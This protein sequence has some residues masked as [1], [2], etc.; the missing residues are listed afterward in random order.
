MNNLLLQLS[1]RVLC[2]LLSALLLFSVMGCYGEEQEAEDDKVLRILVE[3]NDYYDTNGLEYQIELAIQRF[4]KEYPDYQIVLEE[5]PK[6]ENGRAEM[7]QKIRTELMAGK[8]PDV[9]LLSNAYSVFEWTNPREPLFADIELSMRNGLFYDISEFYNAD[10]ALQK[11]ELE[12]VIMEAGVLDGARYVLPLRFDI[13]VM[14]VEKNRFAETGLSED[15]FEMGILELI[16]YF[17]SMEDDAIAS[18][19][20]L[21]YVYP[22]FAMNMFPR[23]FDYD[24]GSVAVTR[25]EIETFLRAFQ[26]YRL[27]FVKSVE[28]HDVSDS[29]EMHRYTQDGLYWT[30]QTDNFLLI[31]SLQNMLEILAIG[32]TKGAELEAY[33]LRSADGSVVADITFYGAVS[34]GSKHPKL[35]YEFIRLFLTKNYQWDRNAA[36]WIGNYWYLSTYGWPVRTK[37]SLAEVAQS[38]QEASKFEWAPVKYKIDFGLLTNEDLLVE[39]LP[40]DSARFSIALEHGFWLDMKTLQKYGLDGP[41]DVDIPKLAQTWM[42]RLQVHIDEG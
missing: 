4:A 15:L 22:Q 10:T 3:R 29:V 7:L 12:P 42:E 11:G 26:A 14:F 25:E 34:A 8:G 41:T 13:P 35:A 21:Q 20:F 1:R 19:F 17:V 9:L 27:R 16:D 33:P 31:Q 38:A 40:I 2:G 23:L 18:N 36:P 30:E 32:K 24:K 6:P 39:E 5:L 37:G 28:Q